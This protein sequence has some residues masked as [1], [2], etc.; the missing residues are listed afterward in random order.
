MLL[1]R[2]TIESC[3]D[4]CRCDDDEP[5]PYDQSDIGHAHCV[6]ERARKEKRQE[7]QHEPSIDGPSRTHGSINEK[8]PE[9]GVDLSDMEPERSLR[10]RKRG[11]QRVR[12]LRSEGAEGRAPI[13][14]LYPR[15]TRRV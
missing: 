6:H 8:V 13:I 12:E 2:A 14:E 5:L 9:Q 10:P 1:A 3:K 15:P 7:H 4:G 11:E